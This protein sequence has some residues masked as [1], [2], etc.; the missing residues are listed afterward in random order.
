MLPAFLYIVGVKRP[1]SMATCRPPRDS[2][3]TRGWTLVV[4]EDYSEQL[5]AQCQ[6]QLISSH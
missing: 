3:S 6:R 2:N 1:F 5:S 4:K